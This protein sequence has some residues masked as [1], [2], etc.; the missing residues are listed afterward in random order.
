[1]EFY[2]SDKCNF[3][4]QCGK[5]MA[6]L[7]KQRQRQ[8]GKVWALLAYWS[9]RASW[10]LVFFDFLLVWETNC[11]SKLVRWLV[12][13]RKGLQSLMRRDRKPVFRALAWCVFLICPLVLLATRNVC[14]SWSTWW[15]YQAIKKLLRWWHKCKQDVKTLSIRSLPYL[16]PDRRPAKQCRSSFFLC[17]LLWPP[18]MSIPDTA[19]QNI[20][21][22]KV[23]RLIRSLD[24]A[25]GS[26][27]IISISS[28]LM[29]I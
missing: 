6:R 1:M 16:S 24:A 11:W 14:L 17:I 8:Q 26:A 10:F 28:R 3:S 5:S 4:L 20:Q 29:D 2:A 7:Q 25:R 18:T 22:W 12:F 21:M 19:D 9:W 15:I 23:K 27:L 13:Q